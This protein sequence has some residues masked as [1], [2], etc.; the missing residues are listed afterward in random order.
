[1]PDLGNYAFH[2]LA[3][4]GAISLVILIVIIWSLIKHERVRKKLLSLANRNKV[5]ISLV[6]SIVNKIGIYDDSLQPI[7]NANSFDHFC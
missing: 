2:V 3:S 7:V 4:Y 1:M 6:G 5:N